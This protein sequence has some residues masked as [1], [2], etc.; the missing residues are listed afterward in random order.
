MKK[1]TLLLL[2]ITSFSFGQTKKIFHKSHSGSSSTMFLDAN[3]NFGPGMAPVRYRTPESPIKLNYVISSKNQYP[4]VSLDTANKMMR[5]YDLQDSLIGCDRN[6]TEYLS[7]GSMVYDVVSKEFWVYQLYFYP[8]QQKQIRVQRWFSIS[9]SLNSWEAKPNFIRRRNAFIR[10]GKNKRIIM[11]YPLLD[12]RITSLLHP[13]MFA[14]TESFPVQVS[15]E[16]E[17]EEKKMTRKEKRIKRK[18]AR[19]NKRIK[20]EPN[21]DNEEIIFGISSPKPPTGSWLIW[22][23]IFFFGFSIFIF[24]GIKQIV[25]EELGKIN[26][27]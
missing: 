11:S 25:K 8:T 10:D 15:E 13:T 24:V 3:N 1:T 26:K 9:D 7:H 21:K 14:K 18:Q 23:G 2:L 4:I 12:H 27:R 16:V 20:E 6:Y 22:L 17:R 5:F 19:K